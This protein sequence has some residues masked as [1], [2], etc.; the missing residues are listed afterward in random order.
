MLVDIVS[1]FIK[2]R[3]PNGFNLVLFVCQHCGRW[4]QQTF[5]HVKQLFSNELS[6]ISALIF[7]GCDGLIHK[8]REDYVTDFIKAK[9]AIAQFMQKGIHT[10]SFP[11]VT[12]MDPELQRKYNADRKSDQEHLCQLVYSSDVMKQII[13]GERCSIA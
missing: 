5:D 9:P 10:V 7:T 6:S 13:K 12:K 3:V 8:A 2:E 4:D 11:D 1:D